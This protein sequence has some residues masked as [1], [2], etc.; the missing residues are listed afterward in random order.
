MTFSKRLQNVIMQTLSRDTFQTFV[1]RLS[2]NFTRL[3]KLIFMFPS[4][5][6]PRYLCVCLWSVLKNNDIQNYFK[7]YAQKYCLEDI[8]V[9]SLCRRQKGTFSGGLLVFWWMKIESRD[10]A[11]STYLNLGEEQTSLTEKVVLKIKLTIF[12]YRRDQN[13]SMFI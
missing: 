1:G 6:L 13:I 4:I 10:L 8:S 7:R 2:T 5:Y 3:Q 11:I 12:E 9:T